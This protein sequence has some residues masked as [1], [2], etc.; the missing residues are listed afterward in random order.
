MP[1]TSRKTSPDL[2]DLAAEKDFIP[3][4]QEKIG[5]NDKQKWPAASR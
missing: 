4:I 2:D 1:F 3:E 5:T